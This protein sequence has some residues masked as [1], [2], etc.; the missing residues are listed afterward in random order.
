MIRWVLLALGLAA[1]GAGAWVWLSAPTGSSHEI[2][3]ASRAE[4]ERVLRENP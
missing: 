4:M 3:P 1:V 2:G